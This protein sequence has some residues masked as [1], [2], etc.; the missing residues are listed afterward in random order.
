MTIVIQRVTPEG[1]ISSFLTE[2]QIEA[3][4]GDGA[5]ADAG[6]VFDDQGNFYLAENAFGILKFDPDLNGEIWVSRAVG[7][8]IARASRIA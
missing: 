4:T 8:A 5:A 3:V 6:I 1:E 2:A 7:N